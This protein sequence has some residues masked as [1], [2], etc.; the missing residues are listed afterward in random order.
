VEQADWRKV[1]KIRVRRL[2]PVGAAAG[3]SDQGMP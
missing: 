3:S 2:A 1:E